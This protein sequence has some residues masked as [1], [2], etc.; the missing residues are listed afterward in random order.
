MVC[1]HPCPFAATVCRSG[2]ENPE[3]PLTSQRFRRTAQLDGRAPLRKFHEGTPPATVA[4]QGGFGSPRWAPAS[5]RPLPRRRLRTGTFP[6]TTRGC[7]KGLR[8]SRQLAQ[9]P[10]AVAQLVRLV[11]C[12]APQI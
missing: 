1:R 8:P 12:P 2:P 11:A 5:L 9:R 3:T 4:S 6:I 7:L 10:V